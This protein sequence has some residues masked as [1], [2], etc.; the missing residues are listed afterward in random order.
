M[1]LAAGG[2]CVPL[3]LLSWFLQDAVVATSVESFKIVKATRRSRRILVSDE[4]REYVEIDLTFNQPIYAQICSSRTDAVYVPASGNCAACDPGCVLSSLFERSPWVRGLATPNAA[5]PDCIC[6]LSLEEIELRVQSWPGDPGFESVERRQAEISSDMHREAYGTAMWQHPLTMAQVSCTGEQNWPYLQRFGMN[7]P[8]VANSLWWLRRFETAFGVEDVDRLLQNASKDYD[9]N[10]AVFFVPVRTTRNGREQRYGPTLNELT[11]CSMAL[12]LLA[13]PQ[14]QP[15]PPIE[16]GQLPLSLLPCA[17]DGLSTAQRQYEA[18]MAFVRTAAK[19]NVRCKEDW[20]TS[21]PTQGSGAARRE[22]EDRRQ[23][24]QASEERRSEQEAQTSSEAQDGRRHRRI[25]VLAMR[26]DFDAQPAV[27]PNCTALRWQ[28][29]L[30]AYNLM[31]RALSYSATDALSGC[32][33]LME[34]LVSFRKENVRVLTDAC[35]FRPDQAEYWASPCCDMNAAR[36]SCCAVKNAT[37]ETHIPVGANATLAQSQCRSDPGGRSVKAAVNAAISWRRRLMSS[38]GSGACWRSLMIQE[39][40]HAGTWRTIKQCHA[41]VM[42]RY[43]RELRMSVGVPCLV[44]S[45]CFTNCQKPTL[46]S[47]QTRVPV[48][49][50]STASRQILG[51]CRVPTTSRH[52]YITQCLV[53]RTSKEMLDH[54]SEEMGLPVGARTAK[55]LENAA[56]PPSSDAL[57]PSNDDR[58]IHK[59]CIGPYAPVGVPSTQD[60][61]LAPVLCNWN[62]EVRTQEE[63]EQEVFMN[64]Y[65]CNCIEGWCFQQSRKTGCLTGS[66]TTDFCF[67]ARDTLRFVEVRCAAEAE[68]ALGMKRCN[69]LTIAHSKMLRDCLQTRCTPVGVLLM[70]DEGCADLMYRTLPQCYDKCTIP[71]GPDPSIEQETCFIEL[72]PNETAL[73]CYRVQGDTEVHYN[74]SH[75]SLKVPE[76]LRPKYCSVRVCRRLKDNDPVRSRETEIDRL[77]YQSGVNEMADTLS[78]KQNEQDLRRADVYFGKNPPETISCD[79]GW[80]PMDLDS[81]VKC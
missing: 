46:P 12:P 20:R 40:A 33:D 3:L 45:D 24:Q 60:T 78:E 50:Y 25:G 27:S 35:T 28:M 15:V 68:A 57:G 65:I 7:G 17:S 21:L 64:D 56:A 69:D 52:V 9:D 51:R 19:Q 55:D 53:Q 8:P 54:L 47:L 44:D 72:Q 58:R 31:Q 5:L 26:Q 22:E 6:G 74:A 43:D 49:E 81:L 14:G 4:A 1:A 39:Q 77:A 41:A 30:R 79:M 34:R 63:C 11:R 61:C 18:V 73:D 62:H 67:Q 29:R 36:E 37:V 75:I 76:Y 59:E 42:G 2:V 23:E 70:S 32:W 80:L 48:G 16:L 10:R 38:S 13:G 66:L 71:S